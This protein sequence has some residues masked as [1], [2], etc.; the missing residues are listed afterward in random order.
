MTGQT[1]DYAPPPA[2]ISRPLA[3]PWRAEALA[4]AEAG[5]LAGARR[6]FLQVADKMTRLY[7]HLHGQ[8]A[9]ESGT[10]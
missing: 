3:E 4:V 10:L 5:S 6:L 7:R 8:H 2:A 1:A 9:K